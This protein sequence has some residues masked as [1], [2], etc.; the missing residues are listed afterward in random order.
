MKNLSALKLV[1][2]AANS[3]K[4]SVRFLSVAK[5]EEI[6]FH[7][8]YKTL[9]F[10]TENVTDFVLSKF[11]VLFSRTHFESAFF[12]IFL[13]FQIMFSSFFGFLGF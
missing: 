1:K 5:P 4:S 11:G 13:S 7:S 3:F 9:S 8:P 2:N 10:P 12:F 6:V